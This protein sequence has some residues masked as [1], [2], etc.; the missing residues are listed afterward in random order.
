MPKKP[1]ADLFTLTCKLNTDGNVELEY[2]SVNPD[3][4][5]RE[6]EN[7]FP[8]YEGTFKVSSLIRYLKQTGDEVMNNSGRYV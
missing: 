3:D 7:K 8:Q 4:F 6:M 5:A 1:R 2:S